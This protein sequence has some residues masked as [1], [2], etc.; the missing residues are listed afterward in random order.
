MNHNQRDW[1]VHPPYLY[2][3]YK[4]TVFRAP[5]K[6]LIPIKHT[7]SESTGPVY[8]QDSVG[9]F[10][11]DLTKNGIRN[12]E[13]LGERIVVSGRILDID[14]RPIKNT[15]VEIWQANAAGRYIHKVDQHNAPLDPNF[16]GGGRC[17][18]D[19]N[20]RYTF[21]TIKPGAYPWG[22]HPNAWRPNHI[23]FSLFGSN[24]TN[25]LVTQMYFP[26]DPLLQYDPIYQGVPEKARHL[27]VSQFDL[28]LTQPD[29]AL[30]Y[31][32]DIVLRGHNATP[33]ENQ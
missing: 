2:P 7:L 15:L 33:F 23:H 12:G 28:S 13:P 24:I 11:N 8:G 18:T 29:F 30:G 5:S 19:E 17:V 10:D 26:G 20:G 14:G 27:L 6:P 4:S 16:F 31:N 21:M 1:E 25:R 32:F 9:Q 22:N 3:D